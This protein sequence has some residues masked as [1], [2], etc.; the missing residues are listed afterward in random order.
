MS[1]NGLLELS[2][3]SLLT[4]QAA[5]QT[6]GQNVANASVEGYARRRMDLQATNVSSLGVHTGFGREANGTGVKA[7]SYERQRDALLD[8]SAW[9]TQTGLGASEEEA[10]LLSALE[11]SWASG[12]GG[13]LNDQLGSFFESWNTVAN[14]PT[15]VGARI[16]LRSQAESIAGSIR[17][18]YSDLEAFGSDTQ[19]ALVGG[20]SEINDLLGQVAALNKTI[21]AA[22]MSGT[23][24]LVAEDA[25]D[26][27]VK[28]LS[29][30]MPLRVAEEANGYR[31]TVNGMAVVQGTTASP[32]RV[33]T[34]PDVAEAQ[35]LF[36]GSD[37]QFQLSPQGEDG[38]LGAWLR[39]VNQTVPDTKAGLDALASR[40]VTDV[41]AVHSGAVNA[42]GATGLNFF[43]PAGVTA[44]TLALSADIDDPAA[45]A[46]SAAV[47]A[48]GDTTPAQTIASLSEGFT[49][50]ATDLVTRVGARYQRV[51][52]ELG[53]R[54][55]EGPSSKRA[56]ATPGSG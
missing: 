51:M 36:G 47:G 48:L 38:R 28:T 11:G 7:T 6:T 53:G 3:R 37:V 54:R 43:D 40:L 20:V 32:L 27:I 39:T 33:K 5:I 17:S 52:A 8:R 49:N 13:S 23:P 25:R 12:S 2:R 15:D 41:N 26:K 35:V 44:S 16:A 22:Q 4:H 45:I 30:F 19:N 9:D 34:P 50:E 46:T 24:D 10:K 21:Q 14:R 18:L 42:A 1:I 31:L 55:C 56:M 29:S